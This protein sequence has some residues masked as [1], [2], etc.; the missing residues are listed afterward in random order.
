MT[1]MVVLVL[2]VGGNVSQGILKALALSTV[3]RRVI[4]ACVS[5]LSLGLYTVDRAYVSPPANAPD[6][7][8]W[9]IATCRRENVQVILSGVEP[10]LDVLAEHTAAIQVQTGATCLVSASAQLAISRDK[11]ATC[12]WL[13]SHGL[14]YPR[15]APADDAPALARLVAEC[16][17]PLLAKP[18]LGKG[19]QGVIEVRDESDVTY[20]ARRPD[21]VVQEHIGTPDD[22][23]TVGCFV[24][25]AGQ[26]RGAITMRRELLHGTTYRAEV[27]LF[28]EVRAEAMRI[29]AAIGPLGP[30]N[31]QLRV[32]E[33][34]PV[35]FEIN[36]RFSGTTPIRARLGFNE[37]DAA[38]RHYVLGESAADLP[39]ITEGIVL[40]YWNE[41]YV[42]PAAYTALRTSG[43]LD[44]PARFTVRVED[45]GKQA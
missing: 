15:Y 33:G 11:L 28:P 36:M 20:V 22:E 44:A 35:C 2:G 16:G 31:I 43:R 13:E 5:P 38:L 37:V 25:R 4:G 39:L 24:D 32:A 17:F 6:F 18:R 34:R 29:A 42:D 26:V 14:S 19:G 27:G 23:Y 30:C 41:M 1:E 3:P 40:R 7:L 9:L 8:D 12:Q 21:Y 10:V 45:Y